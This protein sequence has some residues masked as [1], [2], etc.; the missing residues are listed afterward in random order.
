MFEVLLDVIEVFVSEGIEKIVN[1][2]SEKRAKK[3]QE[4]SR[5]F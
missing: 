4:K 1:F 2:F 5:L 3:K